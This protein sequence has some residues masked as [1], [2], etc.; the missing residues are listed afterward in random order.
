VDDT[1]VGANAGAGHVA[2]IGSLW[3]TVIDLDDLA[4]V[5]TWPPDLFALVNRALEASE[6]YR[7]VVSPPP[8]VQ[9]EGIDDN[10]S[11]IA[12]DW[13][14]W[15]DCRSGGLPGPLEKSWGLVCRSLD[16]GILELCEGG[17]WHVTEALLTLHAI[18]DEAC[19]GLGTAT[20]VAPGAGLLFRAAAR[21]LLAEQG[22][23][24]RMSPDVIRVFPRCRTNTGGMSIHSLSR[25]VCVRG[26][27][28]DVEWHRMLSRP[29]GVTFPEAHA[30]IV[31]LPWPLRVRSRDFRPVPFRL[32]HMEVTEFGFFEFDPHEKLDLSLVEGVLDSAVDEAG[33]VDV[34]FLP[35]ASLEK[36][37]IEP[38]ETLAA[39]FGVWC[40]IAGVRELPRDDQ[41]GANWV[42]VGVRQELVWCHAV[43]HKH[44]R[45]CL[46]DRQIRQY[47]LGGALSPTMRWW[48][49]VSI[50]RRSLQVID[51]GAVTIVPLLCEDLARLEPVADLVRAIGPSLVV[52][53]LL[54]GPQLASRWT[55][56]YASV[57]ADDPGSAVCTVTSYGMVR[58][59]RPPGCTQSTVV[60]LWK[61]ASGETT[62]ITL[63]DGAD[64]VLIST[65]PTVGGSTTA[66]GRRH[67][68]TTSGLRLAAVRS[69]RALTPGARSRPHRAAANPNPNADSVLP[70]LAEQEVSKATSWA[71]AVAEAAMIAPGS[72]DRLLTAA[73][74]PEWRSHLGLPPPTAAFERSVA[75]LRRELTRP[76]TPEALLSATAELRASSEPMDVVTGTLLEVAL[77]QRLFAEVQ[78]GRVSSDVFTLLERPSRT[79][80][81]PDQAPDSAESP[82]G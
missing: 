27:Q 14:E 9:F 7:L 35:E 36:A 15:L 79:T 20:A 78:A 5:V 13:L 48:E 31:L 67:P 10:A 34:I 43:Q 45:W 60:A 6:A 26:P 40:V 72:V 62:E 16:T 65:H 66:D 4:D 77:E 29:E 49:A 8:H 24:S 19:A 61:D 39:E 50:P 63:D 71:E 22:S 12:R 1:S 54:D 2:T 11:A 70:Q 82:L 3:R 80:T 57:L 51:Q 38:L 46:D 75:S 58:R 64:A 68:G 17:A 53:L 41:L 23:L 18:A 30:N 55:A 74:D 42:H 21:E 44:H 76:A 32:P 37:D 25:H 81:G 56:R 47:H 59:C 73:I 69:L 33:S 52:T 28:V